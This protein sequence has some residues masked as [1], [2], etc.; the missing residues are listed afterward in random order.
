MFHRPPD[1]TLYVSYPIVNFIFVLYG[2][3]FFGLAVPFEWRI[4]FSNPYSVTFP[5][6]LPT[7]SL[8]HHP[9][10]GLPRGAVS[11]HL[12]YIFLIS[13]LSAISSVEFTLKSLQTVLL[14]PPKTNTVYFHIQKDH[15]HLLLTKSSPLISF[16]CIFQSVPWPW[17][18]YFQIS[19][20]TW[21]L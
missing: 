10:G 5:T 16:P 4:L 14:P 17:V 9:N 19:P 15:Y 7:P 1:P 8:P 18:L 20:I 13:P 3:A 2:V 6:L 12:C 21:P 11:K